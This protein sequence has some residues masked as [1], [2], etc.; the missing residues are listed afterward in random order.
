M[1]E[2]RVSDAPV[3][4]HETS[5]MWLAGRS[6]IIFTWYDA[7]SS[8]DERCRRNWNTQI[9]LR[10]M[11]LLADT[12]C[13]LQ[14]RA[15][16]EQYRHRN[17]SQSDEVH[18]PGAGEYGYHTTAVVVAAVQLFQRRALERHVPPVDCCAF[19]ESE[20]QEGIG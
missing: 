19:C 8:L 14:Q 17:A 12:R 13:A 20:D 7:S 9:R 3:V 18:R 6:S 5:A 10:H 2:I 15:S 16:H 1:I 4:L 11:Y